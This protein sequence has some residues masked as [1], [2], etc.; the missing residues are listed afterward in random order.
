MFRIICT[1][2]ATALFCSAAFAEDLKPSQVKFI[3]DAEVLEPLT[4]QAG[5]P[6]AGREWYAGRKLGNCLACHET[7]DLKEQP[8]HGEVGPKMDGVAERYEPAEMR[9]IIVNSKKVF[10]EETLMPG[11][12]TLVSGARVADKFAGKTILSAQQVEDVIAYL[13]TLK[14]E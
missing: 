3:D 1:V 14:E 4:S 7:T 11:F 6:A 5:D 10:G 8:F 2:A 9:A 12:Y 13:Q